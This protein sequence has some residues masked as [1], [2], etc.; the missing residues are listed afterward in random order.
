MQHD[1]VP[2]ILNATF[3]VPGRIEKFLLCK[4][5]TFK[6]SKGLFGGTLFWKFHLLVGAS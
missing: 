5:Q 2:V 4:V 6:Q 3:H 1:C